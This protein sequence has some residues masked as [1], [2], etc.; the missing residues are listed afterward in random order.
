MKTYTVVYLNN[1]LLHPAAFT[2]AARSE[3]DAVRALRLV[4]KHDESIAEVY[5]VVEIPQ[6]PPA[7][8]ND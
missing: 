7:K 1:K 8:Y 3:F 5:A 6:T 4:R 2:T